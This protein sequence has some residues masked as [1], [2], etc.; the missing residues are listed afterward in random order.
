MELEAEAA[1]RG[2]RDALIETLEDSVAKLYARHGYHQVAL[3]TGYVG[4]FNRHIMLK[5]SISV[6]PQ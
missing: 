1:R 2:C 4:R 5:P 6:P 3:V